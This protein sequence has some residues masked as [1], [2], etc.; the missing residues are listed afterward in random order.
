MT[1]QQFKETL[2][3]LCWDDLMTV[4]SNRFEYD[5]EKQKAIR[6]IHAKRC[7]EFNRYMCF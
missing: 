3:N 1:L 5:Q 7:S 4:Y 6:E 2:E